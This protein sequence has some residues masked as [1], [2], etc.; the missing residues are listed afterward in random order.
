MPENINQ[1]QN[2]E[3][4]QEIPVE[5]IREANEQANEEI[6][7]DM[8][9]S[10]HTMSDEDVA[11]AST[12]ALVTGNTT[13]SNNY[14]EEE[15]KEIDEAAKNIGESE[16]PAS[17]DEEGKEWSFNEEEAK[18]MLYHRS[19]PEIEHYRN[20]LMH[21]RI[22]HMKPHEGE[23]NEDFA[24]RQRKARQGAYIIGKVQNSRR[25]LNP[26]L[27]TFGDKLKYNGPLP[28]KKLNEAELNQLTNQIYAA[29]TAAGMNHA[30]K[31]Y[32]QEMKDNIRKNLETMNN[33]GM[34]GA[35]QR[36]LKTYAKAQNDEKLMSRLVEGLK[37]DNDIPNYSDQLIFE[38]RQTTLRT[39]QNASQTPVAETEQQ[40]KAEI[41]KPPQS[42][43][44]EEK[45]KSDEQIDSGDSKLTPKEAELKAEKE[46][47]DRQRAELKKQQD[48]F[49][50]QVEEQQKKQ[51][52]KDSEKRAQE[53][54]D[55][56]IGVVAAVGVTEA[57]KEKGVQFKPVF[58]P[59]NSDRYIGTAKVYYDKVLNKQDMANKINNLSNS[60]RGTN[61]SGSEAAKVLL[62]NAKTQ[63][64]QAEIVDIQGRQQLAIGLDKEAYSL[65]LRDINNMTPSEIVRKLDNDRDK[66]MKSAKRTFDQM[67]RLEPSQ[68]QD[69]QKMEEHQD[70]GMHM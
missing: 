52:Q 25:L 42:E 31:E 58:D 36:T 44:E 20:E 18:E 7:I 3:A 22:P 9:D 47:L 14:T 1:E 45:V 40:K 69:S 48:E 24:E 39:S 10:R 46:E 26:E 49:K 30:G 56:A 64:M 2:L 70:R 11:I 35:L 59:N 12:Q 34:Q 67:K 53:A 19:Y 55:A 51:Q 5:E 21:D 4:T 38:E 13:V 50:K 29:T 17:S 61:M 15:K 60:V 66:M 54:G 8:N 28:A 63:G 43:A 32:E 65:I 57:I 6:S 41:V 62:Q 16:V 23:S 27:L 68:R 37:T 33:N